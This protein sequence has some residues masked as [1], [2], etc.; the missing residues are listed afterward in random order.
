MPAERPE[1]RLGP[2]ARLPR[3]YRDR[4]IIHSSVDA[5]GRAHWLLAEQAPEDRGSDP[6]DALVVT[7]ED[8]ACHETYLH[9]ELPWRP[10]IEAL[11]DGGFVLASPR[12]DGRAFFYTNTLHGQR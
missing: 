7:V 1:T 9:A 12:A 8:G 6:Y 10:R 4:H 2:Y 11:P 5:F 3:T